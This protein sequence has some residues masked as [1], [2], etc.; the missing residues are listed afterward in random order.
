MIFLKDL[1][2]H[3]LLFCMKDSPK[4]KNLF[5]AE[6]LKDKGHLGK[7]VALQPLVGT[8]VESYVSEAS[9]LSPTQVKLTY[10]IKIEW[11][12]RLSLGGSF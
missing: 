9:E 2:A 1:L 7:I 10:A 8:E 12:T 5:S 11:F 3:I 4:T 6:I